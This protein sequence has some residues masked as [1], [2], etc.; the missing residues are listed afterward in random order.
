[1]EKTYIFGEKM[2]FW[3]KKPEF[4]KIQNG[5]RYRNHHGYRNFKIVAYSER[6]TS[7]LYNGINFITIHK[8]KVYLICDSKI[9]SGEYILYRA[10]LI[11]LK[12]D[13]EYKI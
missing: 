5:G 3:L 1:M 13:L 2:Q 11:G 9:Y 8:G 7:Q 12:G 10:E 6:E 4:E